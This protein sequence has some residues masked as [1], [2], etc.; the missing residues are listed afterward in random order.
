[1]GNQDGEKIC[2][3]LPTNMGIGGWGSLGRGTE[4]RWGIWNNSRRIYVRN[5]DIPG[6]KQ[7]EGKEGNKDS[8][9]NIFF[10]Q[11][12]LDFVNFTVLST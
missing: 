11:Q 3:V 6:R 2:V 9:N 1:M 8:M 12:T 5:R 4:K 7:R 10:F